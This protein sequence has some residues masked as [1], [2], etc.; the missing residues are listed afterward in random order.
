MLYKFSN[1]SFGRATKLER[2]ADSLLQG[3][4]YLA[5]VKRPY[6][7]FIDPDHLPPYLPRWWPPHGLVVG[8]ERW[9]VGKEKEE[10]LLEQ[11]NE[12]LTQCK[13]KGVNPTDVIV[14]SLE[15]SVS[16]GYLPGEE[17]YY[18]LAGVEFVKKGYLVMKTNLSGI[19]PIDDF[20]AFRPSDLERGAFLLELTLGMVELKPPQST[21]GEVVFMEMEDT[22]REVS[23]NHGLPKVLGALSYFTQS[24]I[25][26][27]FLEDYVKKFREGKC[28]A[29]SYP[30]TRTSGKCP[31][32]GEVLDYGIITWSK[33]SEL[34]F[35]ESRGEGKARE[36]MIREINFWVDKAIKNC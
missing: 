2:I 4:K 10:L 27:P 15:P 12:L 18:Y 7:G 28:P 32:C 24:Y 8:G 29:C 30:L 36:D 5:I 11:I 14:Y 13:E 21:E 16:G 19:G 9:A 23:Q 33:T 34:F 35:K 22:P 31:S 25:V 17:F 20:F 6:T 1:L 3:E 26:A